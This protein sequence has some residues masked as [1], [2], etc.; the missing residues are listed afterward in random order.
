MDTKIN[1]GTSVDSLFD[2]GEISGPSNSEIPVT[3]KL[4]GATEKIKEVSMSTSKI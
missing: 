1:V 2:D 4:C 3:E